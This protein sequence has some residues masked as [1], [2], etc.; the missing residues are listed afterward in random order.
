MNG[1]LSHYWSPSGRILMVMLVMLVIP[2]WHEWINPI[3]DTPTIHTSN[4]ALL[5]DLTY[6]TTGFF[7]LFWILALNH[8]EKVIHD[9]LISRE[10]LDRSPFFIFLC[11]LRHRFKNGQSISCLMTDSLSSF[12]LLL[13]FSVAV[14]FYFAASPWRDVGGSPAP[15]AMYKIIRNDVLWKEQ[16]QIPLEH[17]VPSVYF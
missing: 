9:G 8:I 3:T 5:I 12:L 6:K 4:C 17:S 2:L 10:S 1:T 11:A 7:C 14:F 16:S 15:V 13:V